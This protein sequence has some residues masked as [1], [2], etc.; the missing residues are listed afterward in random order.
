MRIF[1]R[2]EMKRLIDEV[3]AGI[4]N[5]QNNPLVLGK[6]Q[7]FGFTPENFTA[8][9]AIRLEA[10]RLYLTKGPKAGQKIS[11]SIQLREEIE[12]IHSIFMVYEKM[13]RRD[14]KD[15]PALFSEFSLSGRRDYSISGKIKEPKGFYLN[16][17]D[18]EKVG[19]YVTKYGLTP[20]AIQTHLDRIADLEKNKTVQAVLV[21]ESEKTTEDRNKIFLQLN[22][23]WNNYKTVLL[24]VFKDDPQQLEALRIK[25]YSLNYKPKR[26][27][28][29]EGEEPQ[30]AEPVEEPA[31]PPA[32]EPQGQT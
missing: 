21:K 28:S 12:Q 4:E 6:V 16:C 27:G 3:G 9:E 24:H 23:W 31:E 22:N 17:Q 8:T 1:T 25:G 18:N 29:D 26:G 15:D 30:G 2:K 14:L 7:G 19:A 10:E 32:E 20:E 11:L 5:S 13:L